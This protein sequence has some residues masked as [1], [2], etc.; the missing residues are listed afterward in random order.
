MGSACVDS[1]ARQG[2]SVIG[3]DA[4]APFSPRRA[5]S[6]G[7]RLWRQFHPQRPELTDA[8]RA[9]RELWADLETFAGKSLFT[10]TG[11]VVVSS[12]GRDD[13]LRQADEAL[14]KGM[15]G[16]L[17]AG[18]DLRALLPSVVIAEGDC[19]LYEPRAG[20]LHAEDCLAALRL[21]ALDHGARLLFHQSANL[22]A[23]DIDRSPLTVSTDSLTIACDQMVV[24]TGGWNAT[25][26]LSGM[27]E[28]QVERT[29]IHWLDSAQHIPYDASLPF[30][31]FE[32][33]ADTAMGLV[34]PV[35]RRGLKFGRFT[36]GQLV[37]PSVMPREVTSSEVAAD[38]M[39]LQTRIPWLGANSPVA[40]H[41]CL[42]SH[43][44]DQNLHVTQ[45][46]TS[47]L[48]VSA[49]EGL[50]FKFAPLLGEYVSS[51]LTG[52]S[53]NRATWLV[54]GARHPPSSQR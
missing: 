38:L 35:G 26:D 24:A 40:S 36:T 39:A 20:V 44:A 52:H 43:T 25:H 14:V 51:R 23:V 27:P 10:A 17:L 50:G 21:R 49:C 18:T 6:G 2:V 42:H 48:A 45:L 12:V 16:R 47:V 32:N 9:A 8:A 1:L 33:D 22:A 46:S 30:A 28:V 3:V 4:E 41:A 19:A 34:P 15:P 29:V 11:G 54:T 5:S 31:I 53:P 7:S 13:W 37:D